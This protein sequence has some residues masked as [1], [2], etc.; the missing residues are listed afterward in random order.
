MEYGP[1]PETA[2]AQEIDDAMTRSSVRLMV[3]ALRKGKLDMMVSV[4]PTGTWQAPLVYSGN[5]AR[6]FRLTD[7][8]GKKRAVRC[9]Y[10]VPDQEH[11][12]RYTDIDQYFQQHI[13][14]I[15]A[16]FR[17]HKQGIKIKAEVPP[18]IMPIMEMEWVDGDTLTVCLDRLAKQRDT[19]RI[20]L[21]AERWID[22]IS[23]MNRAG[24]AHGDLSGTNVM[25]RRADN[26]LVLIDYD[27]VFI[28]S[29]AGRGTNEAG[30]PDY[31][32]HDLQNRLYNERMD[33]FSALVIYI[34]LLSIS[35]DP[36]LW[37][38]FST[39]NSDTGELTTD[40]LLFKSHDLSEP[41]YSRLFTRLG[42]IKDPEL[43]RLLPVLRDACH[44]PVT[45]VPD[46]MH[47]VNPF[48]KHEAALARLKADIASSDERAIVAAAADPILQGYKPA[49]DPAIQAEVGLATAHVRQADEL[50][51][52]L[53]RGDEDAALQVWARGGFERTPIGRSLAARVQAIQQRLDRLRDLRLA[54]ANQDDPAIAAAWDDDIFKGYTPALAFL[55][56]VQE[57]LQRLQRTRPLYEALKSGDDA[58]VELLWLDLKNYGP[59]QKLR[60]QAEAAIERVKV[61]RKAAYDVLT[62][63]IKN[64]DDAGI[65]QVAQNKFL[66]L[67]M[68]DK[69]KRDRV[70]LARE[71]VAQEKELRKLLA[72]EDD[73]AILRVWAHN[74]F[75]KVTLAAP[76]AAQVDQVR[77]RLQKLR[78]LESALADLSN[79]DQDRS[80]IAAWSDALF[81]GY[82][83]A[84][85]HKPAYEAAKG[86]LDRL[87]PLEEAVQQHDDAEIIRLWPSLSAYGPARAYQKT[88]EQAQARI[89]QLR[90]NAIKALENAIK[91]SDDRRILQAW[92]DP[93]LKDLPQVKGYEP[94]VKQAQTRLAAITELEKM[95]GNPDREEEVLRIWQ[96]DGLQSSPL[97]AP[98]RPRIEYI[99]RRRHALEEVGQAAT[100]SDDARLLTV[101]DE[102]LFQ[103]YAPAQ[104]FQAKVAQAKQRMRSIDALAAALSSGND[105]LAM[106]LWDTLKVSELPGASTYD[107]DVRARKLR[108]L[109]GHVPTNLQGTLEQ[110]RLSL[111][112]DWPDD[113]TSAGVAVRPSSGT[114][115][116]GIS[117]SS[118]SFAQ[119]LL[120]ASFAM[121]GKSPS[122]G[123]ADAAKSPLKTVSRVQYLRQGGYTQDVGKVEMLT[124][125]VVP[126]MMHSKEWLTLDASALPQLR[127]KPTS[128]VSYR[129]VRDLDGN[130][131]IEVV[132]PDVSILPTLLVVVSSNRPAANVS[133]GMNIASIGPSQRLPGKN[134]IY[135]TPINLK[136]WPSP[137]YVTLF[138]SNPEDSAW[139]KLAPEGGAPIQIT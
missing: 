31:Q 48:A 22:L 129:L 82:A 61:G 109:A 139:F 104:A 105:R 53:Q 33:N 49:Q 13:S 67:D 131:S 15:T 69:L 32:H 47:V 134:G 64:D 52:C 38:E 17:F 85:A 122:A 111:T 102:R 63:A 127:L 27:G 62:S 124:V 101:W 130:T 107:R 87:K 12:R 114:G 7:A 59:A 90:Q 6:V 1:V 18:F 117:S 81:K 100:R 35:I 110:G 16:D 74:D 41:S 136:G 8:G 71:R 21:L 86:R 132:A 39:H 26:S 108:W 20:R 75:E 55:P 106:M 50:E 36:A 34:A 79:L 28:P 24:I 25:V 29:F 66:N 56:K 60:S 2:T 95:L 88:V 57:A 30:N 40:T 99:K 42:S 93:L 43:Q 19:A 91:L 84:Q 96:R 92:N 118:P 125:S 37:N 116:L 135:R 10:T 77:R 9:F 112:W 68:L 119:S 11:Q 58:T 133:T 46:F 83:R 98:L 5:F 94:R 73:E 128:T 78:Q 126:L 137:S 45:A 121:P 23:Q 72:T 138:L 44:G 4:T 76:L 3:S 115:P 103:G 113:L 97:A 70:K 51:A 54:I 120:P 89:E 65:A 123:T 14:N 80:V